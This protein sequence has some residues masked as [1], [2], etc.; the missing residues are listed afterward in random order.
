M[1]LNR[2]AT[3]SITDKQKPMINNLKIFINTGSQ[4]KVP[5]TNSIFNLLKKHR[6]APFLNTL[7]RLP[8]FF[9]E[10]K[11]LHCTRYI[12][13]WKHIVVRERDCWM[14]VHTKPFG[15]KSKV[16]EKYIFTSTGRWLNHLKRKI[17]YWFT[18]HHKYTL[19]AY[20][21]IL[22]SL[23][24]LLHAPFNFCNTKSIVSNGLFHW[25]PNL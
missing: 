15:E 17:F 13:K 7:Q 9:M 4:S 22:P 1:L 2:L 18:E 8:C 5:S 12:L 24:S 14:L 10:L 20:T 25:I 23:L 21:H 16:E 19:C 3:N 6:N 11:T